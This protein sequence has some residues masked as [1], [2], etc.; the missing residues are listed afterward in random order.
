[1]KGKQDQITLL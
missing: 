1:M